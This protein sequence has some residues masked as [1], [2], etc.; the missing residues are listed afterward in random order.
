M[1]RRQELENRRRWGRLQLRRA[2]ATMYVEE[3]KTRDGNG[4]PKKPR[5]RYPNWVLG[6]MLMAR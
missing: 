6:W 4:N 3:H 1:M 5:Q 2:L